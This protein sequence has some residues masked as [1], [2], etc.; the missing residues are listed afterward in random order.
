MTQKID[1]W[2][3]DFVTL[4]KFELYFDDCILVN[5][6]L[7]T[8][9]YFSCTINIL[10]YLLSYEDCFHKVSSNATGIQGMPCVSDES[11]VYPEAS[12]AT[13]RSDTKFLL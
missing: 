8:C 9:C 2:Q 11:V 13:S 10:C 7:L 6:L 5:V 1:T 4:I 12:A 3:H